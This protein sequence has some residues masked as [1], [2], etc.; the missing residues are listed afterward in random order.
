[1]QTPALTI[2]NVVKKFSGKTIVDIK[3]LEID[4]G[5]AYALIGPNGAGKTTTLR[6]IVGIYRPDNGTIRIYGERAGT[7]KARE[8]IA[9]LPEDAGVYPRLTGWEHINFY[10]R[11]YMDDPREAEEKAEE[12]AKI[13][14]LGKK[15][16][17]KAS[18]YSKG[19]KRRLLL[20]IVLA[21]QRPLTI[22]DEPTSGLDVFT[23]V[24]IRRMIRSLHGK[25]TILLTSHNMLE[26]EQV[27]EKVGFL[28]NGRIIA[29]GEPRELTAR[30]GAENL[31]EA[32]VKAVKESEKG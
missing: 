32:F 2:N 17:D 22:L 30:Y 29:E 25:T 4:D 8:K 12:A 23:A 26:V 27:A 11:L 14:D 31:E 6:L 10:M 24:K 9:Y 13:A 7:T 20:A 1:M 16:Y 19:M 28:M 3:R 21:L 5:E 15:L 18:T